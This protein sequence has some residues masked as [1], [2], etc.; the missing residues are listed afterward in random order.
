MASGP[1]IPATS[2]IATLPAVPVPLTS[3]GT[4]TLTGRNAIGRRTVVGPV[5][6]MKPV[7]H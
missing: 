4:A 7:A 5:R 3:G 1:V 2:G 6:V